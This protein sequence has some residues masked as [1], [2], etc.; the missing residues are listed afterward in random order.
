MRS[1]FPAFC[2]AVKIAV[3][4]STVLYANQLSL[5]VCL[6]EVNSASAC[7]CS[8]PFSLLRAEHDAFYDF[9]ASH[10]GDKFVPR[11]DTGQRLG[12]GFLL[13]SD[14]VART[15]RCESEIAC[16]LEIRTPFGRRG[17]TVGQSAVSV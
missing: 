9:S 6:T 3:N 2:W 7:A 13:A 8:F 4:H 5:E 14:V 10:F 16:M 1:A 12:I 17:R 11:I 15:Q